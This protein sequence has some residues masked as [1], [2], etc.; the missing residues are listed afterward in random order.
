MREHLHKIALVVH[1]C[2][3]KNNIYF[4]RSRMDSSHP[5]RESL[6][7]LSKTTDFHDRRVKNKY[8]QAVAAT[9]RFMYN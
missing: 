2:A 9:E 5:R 6:P 3:R 8:F 4:F 1:C 7:Y